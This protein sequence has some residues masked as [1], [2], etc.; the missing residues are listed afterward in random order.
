MPI[1][2]CLGEEIPLS[3]EDVGSS[4]KKRTTWRVLLGR[5]AVYRCM[6][7][8][9]AVPGWVT[10]KR[11]MHPTWREGQ[12]GGLCGVTG[13]CFLPLQEMKRIL[14]LLSCLLE[15]VSHALWGS[16]SLSGCPVAQISM[17]RGQADQSTGWV[18]AKGR[19]YDVGRRRSSFFLT[20]P[21]GI[22]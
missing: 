20:S 12:T 4:F 19:R 5:P 17:D 13:A 11:Q 9:H 18:E 7:R 15:E 6:H 8:T 10:R 1:R 22:C 2:C 14:H 3:W 16:S 21:R